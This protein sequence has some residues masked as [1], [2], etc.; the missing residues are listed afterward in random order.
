MKV[1]MKWFEE[2]EDKDGGD[3]KNSI[4][5]GKDSRDAENSVVFSKGVAG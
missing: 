4:V 5:F 3:T 1:K 2:K